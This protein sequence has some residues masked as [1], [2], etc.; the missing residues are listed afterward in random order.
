[1]YAEFYHTHVQC[2]LMKLQKWV[3][4]EVGPDFVSQVPGCL[5]QKVLHSICI[6]LWEIMLGA[7]MQV[8]YTLIASINL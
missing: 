1:M 2:A 5:V 6:K 4:A 8:A 3:L 7:Y